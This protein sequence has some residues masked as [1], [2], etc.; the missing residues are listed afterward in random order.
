M[1][2]VTS[3]SVM[4]IPLMDE[5]EPAPSFLE[6]IQSAYEICHFAW[7]RKPEGRQTFLTSL[8]TDLNS[9][10]R[11][12]CNEVI[13]IVAIAVAFTISRRKLSKLV[14]MDIAPRNPTIRSDPYLWWSVFIFI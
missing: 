6:L 7:H 5:W 4:N 8:G 9:M 11:I 2:T 10:K 1:R 3:A 12:T 14:L 13:V